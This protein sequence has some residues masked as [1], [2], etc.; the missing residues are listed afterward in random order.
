[1]LCCHQDCGGVADVLGYEREPLVRVLCCSSP[2][3][4]AVV[5]GPKDGYKEV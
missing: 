3:L 5:V 4:S 2:F 1:M